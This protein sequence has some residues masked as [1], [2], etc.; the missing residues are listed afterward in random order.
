[1]KEQS[2][3]I[4]S[5][6]ILGYILLITIAVCSV[7]YI[8]NIVEKVAEEDE[9]DHQARRKVYLVTNT[10][11]LLYESEALGQLVGMP[12]NEFR[13]FN[14]TLNK[15]HNNM[16]SLRTLV[17]DSMQLLKIDTID[18]LLERKPA[19]CLRL[20]RKRTRSVFIRRISRK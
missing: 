15:A 1:M 10:L 8:Y 4:T 6:V 3:H 13:H 19:A 2:G 17:T 5:K 20:G 14:R 16:D 12:Q 9:P 7:A 18:I 11:S